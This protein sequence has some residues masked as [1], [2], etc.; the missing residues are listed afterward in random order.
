MAPQNGA[1]TYARTT[2][3]GRP[4]TLLDIKETL[5]TNSHIECTNL[6]SPLYIVEA[7]PLHDQDPLATYRIL[8]H[9]SR[10]TKF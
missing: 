1:N 5:A 10:L 4:S 9:L 7:T 2:Q 3:D 8:K 6:L